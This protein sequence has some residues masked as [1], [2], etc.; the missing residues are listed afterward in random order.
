[1][2][3]VH[4][5]KTRS[6]NMSRITGKNTKPEMIVRRFLF[7]KGFRYKLHDAKLPGKP[8][9]VL[10][11]FKTVVLI[12]GCFWHGHVG[13]KYFVVPKTRTQWWLNKIE[14]NRKRDVQNQKELLIRHIR[15]LS[16]FE[17]ELRPE[18]REQTLATLINDLKGDPLPTDDE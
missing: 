14:A 8:D 13:C 2:T 12:H 3:D 5:S 10:P 4:D 11:K 16:I 18:L 17:C 7:S 9:L 1:M 6:F 15:V